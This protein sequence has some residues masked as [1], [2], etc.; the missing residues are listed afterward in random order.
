MIPKDQQDLTDPTSDP[1][2]GAVVDRPDPA[3][4]D[5]GGSPHSSRRPLFGRPAGTDNPGRVGMRSDLATG[6]RARNELRR[7]NAG[8]PRPPADTVA[9]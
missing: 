2:V 5:E 9:A 1:L 8:L 7:G 6:L 3:L 4:T